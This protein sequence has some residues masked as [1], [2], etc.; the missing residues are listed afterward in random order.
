[1]F[2]GLAKRRILEFWM[3]K[4]IGNNDNDNV[5]LVDWYWYSKSIV[6]YSHPLVVKMKIFVVVV[7]V[8][9]FFFD[10]ILVHPPHH[11]HVY[12]IYHSSSF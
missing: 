7:V 12:S 5:C 1:M 4:W 3:M 6:V 11:H 8:L 2:A 9:F 10:Y